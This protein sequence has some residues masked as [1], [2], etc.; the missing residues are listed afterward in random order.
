MLGREGQDD[1]LAYSLERKA[2]VV[3]KMLPPSNMPLSQLA[4]EEGISVETPAK[5]RA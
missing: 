3:L 1:D 5:W 4:R 2:A